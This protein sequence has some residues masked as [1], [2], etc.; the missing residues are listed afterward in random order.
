MSNEYGYIPEHIIEEVAHKINIVEIINRYVP[1]KKSGSNYVGLCP[2]HNEKTPSFSVSEDKQIFHCFGCGRGGNAYKF[3]MEID[4]ITFPEAVYQLAQITGVEI[5]TKKSS[6][7]DTSTEINKRYYMINGWAKDF[8]CDNLRGD[9]TEE[10]R[11]YLKK[12]NISS[13]SIKLFS[14][15]ITKKDS[16]DAL[17]IFLKSKGVSTKE[18]L[19]L[20]LIIPKKDN[21]GY[22]DRFRNRLMFPIFD[23]T[24]QIA[25]FG[26]RRLSNDSKMQKYL[27]SPETRLFKKSNLLY[28]M[29]I[30]KSHIRKNNTVLLVEGYLDVIQMMQHGIMNCVAPLGTSLTK[31]QV[32]SIIRQTYNFTLVFDGDSAGITASE[33]ACLLISE[34]NGHARVV[35]LPENKDPDEYL[36]YYGKEKLLRLI[37]SPQESI[38]FFLENAIKKNGNERIDQ[39]LKTI[40]DLAPLI[41]NMTTRLEYENSIDKISKELLLSTYAV[42]DAL[43]QLRQSRSFSFNSIV[44][45]NETI[46]DMSIKNQI[47][48]T[49]HLNK[50][51]Q[52]LAYIINNPKFLTQIER[53][54]GRILFDD[55]FHGLYNRVKEKIF[56]NEIITGNSNFSEDTDLFLFIF[57]DL[58]MNLDDFSDF[59][60]VFNQVINHFFDEEHSRIRKNI[61][62]AEKN[63]DFT[64]IGELLSEL[65]FV[66]EQ[67][68]MMNSRSDAN[69][70]K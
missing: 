11:E 32:K 51:G 42:I 50:Q 55:I 39:K 63:K 41:Q 61:I 3:L 66:L 8:F 48:N 56:L 37:E 58:G 45:K 17:F 65:N 60:T 28:G 47:L 25:G 68:K 29:N 10:V 5:P 54:G 62:E 4:N 46:E 40:E 24:G 18:M 35:R 13:E 6:S 27:N 44:K 2:F 16:W 9:H 52:L 21:S 19:E 36:N 69:N 20:G 34:H 12:R 57:S 31:E 15:G 43:K 1:L 49:D 33:R 38:S 64:K 53:C 30:A 23:I 67:K 22:I 7:Y 70:A 14:L 26:G 59:E